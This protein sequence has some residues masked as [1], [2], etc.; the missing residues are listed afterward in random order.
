YASDYLSLNVAIN[1]KRHTQ[2][3]PN[4]FKLLVDTSIHWK[5]C[6][7]EGVRCKTEGDMWT[8]ANYFS[9]HKFGEVDPIVASF[10]GGAVGVISAFI[11]VEILKQQEH[12]RCKYCLGTGYLACARCASTGAIVLIHP[13]TSANSGSQPSTPPKTERCSKVS[14]AG[15]NRPGVNILLHKPGYAAYEAISTPNQL[16]VRHFDLLHDK[17]KFSRIK[18]SSSMRIFQLVRANDKS[19]QLNS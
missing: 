4:L 3:P 1:I 6:S 16:E 15:K 13:V 19:L 10:S 18:G 14:G 7:F 2:T 5:A 9:M 17:G 12:K 11:V 8:I